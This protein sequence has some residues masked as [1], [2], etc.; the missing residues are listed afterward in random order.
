MS[1]QFLVGNRAGAFLTNGFAGL[2]FCM[3]HQDALFNILHPDARPFD[4]AFSSSGRLE[5]VR[6]EGIEEWL[7]PFGIN[8]MVYH[9]PPRPW[10]LDIRRHGDSRQWGRFYAQE[11]KGNTLFVRFT[12]RTDQ[13]EDARHGQEEFSFIVAIEPLD[14]GLQETAS[15]L[16]D[17]GRWVYHACTTQGDAAL[18]AVA[19]DEG[20]VT[21]ILAVLREHKDE[22]MEAHRRLPLPS[23]PI[24][25]A[26]AYRSAV[27]AL[28]TLL[29]PLGK[30]TFLRFPDVDDAEDRLAAV[31]A[32][33]AERE[34]AFAKDLLMHDLEEQASAGRMNE[35]MK[36]LAKEQ[37]MV[38]YFSKDQIQLII[39]HFMAQ[40]V[41]AMNLE[42]LARLTGEERYFDGLRRISLEMPARPK[43]F[44][45]ALALLPEPSRTKEHGAMLMQKVESL[46]DDPFLLCLAGAMLVPFAPADFLD[47]LFKRCKRLMSP[48]RG[49]FQEDGHIDGRAVAAFISFCHARGLGP[50]DSLPRA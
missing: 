18:L 41:K 47:D 37:R 33:I 50:G 10:L 48:C 26:A 14:G 35:M 22:L 28:D 6:Q 32:L 3:V 42:L 21:R 49:Y 43:D 12:K 38:D 46:G 20:E 27:D 36:T 39:D 34:F 4:S 29:M 30:R 8:A 17:Q 16:E 2:G 19:K 24:P 40:P 45:M 5:L 11:R 7:L 1:G 31:S 13:R 44:V 23:S 25:D 15:W 9:G